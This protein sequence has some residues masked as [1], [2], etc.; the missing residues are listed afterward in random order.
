MICSPHN[1]QISTDPPL[2]KVVFHIS[3]SINPICTKL[4]LT[5]LSFLGARQHIIQ[6]RFQKG[7]TYGAFWEPKLYK[8]FHPVK[9][10][11]SLEQ[12]SRNCK[13][14]FLTIHDPYLYNFVQFVQLQAYNTVDKNSTFQFALPDFLLIH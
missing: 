10:H 3:M 14:F 12:K 4:D 8:S 6:L 9:V 5:H 1:F 2:N 11:F 13:M 7:E